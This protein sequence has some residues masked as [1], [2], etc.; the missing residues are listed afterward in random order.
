MN[1]LVTGATGF[2]GVH[3]CKELVAAGHDVIGLDIHP[4]HPGAEVFLGDARARIANRLVDIAEPGA[5]ERALDRR[6][7]AVV[8]AAI[9]ATSSGLEV[10][11]PERIVAVNVVGTLEV[12]RAAR[13]AGAT[14]FVYISSSG[15]YGHT[16]PSLTLDETRTLQLTNIY[17]VAKYSSERITEWFGAEEGMTTAS[18]RIAAPYG[19]LERATGTRSA[20]SPVYRL[21]H[22]A[23]EG[24]SIALGDGARSRDWTHAT[25]ISRALR[26]L[27][28]AP[29]LRH[30]CYNVSSGVTRPLRDVTAIL[31]RLAPEFAWRESA[32]GGDEGEIP[33]EIR[34]PVNVERIFGEGFAPRYSLEEGLEECLRW[35]RKLRASGIRL[36]AGGRAP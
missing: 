8:H 25:D 22:A 20:M 14:R 30:R 33:M 17:P 5:V 28:E 3:L 23:V 24:R 26:V 7:D 27:I 10:K 36:D 18:A 4:L 13:S 9:V 1:V 35:V 31:G 6:V 21:V 15:V 11:N 2:I 29:S 16:D 32:E 12:L 34:G 19:P